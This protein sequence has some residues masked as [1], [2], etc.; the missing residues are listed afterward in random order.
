MARLQ[1]IADIQ[2]AKGFPGKRRPKVQRQIEEAQ[3]LAALLAAAPAESGDRLAPPALLADPRLA[4]AL[5]VWRE[6]TPRLARLNLFGKLDRHTF[7]IFCVYCAEFAAAQQDIMDNGYSRLVMTLSGDR[8]PRVNPSV[9][10]RDTAQKIILEMAH[11]FG[12]TP[13]DQY[14]LIRHQAGSGVPAGGLF[15]AAPAPAGQATLDN[16]LIG[17]LADLDSP[18]PTKLQ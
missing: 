16:D 13:L 1:D 2:V 5:A 11:R 15:T 12:L 3:K 4:A 14:A 18:A 8:M 6:Y 9:D 10:R 17:S 7:A